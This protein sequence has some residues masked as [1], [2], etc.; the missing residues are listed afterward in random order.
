MTR[1]AASRNTAPG[2]PLT[3]CRS[4]CSPVS[5]NLEPSP[6]N[7][8]ATLSRP[9][10]TRIHCGAFPPPSPYTSTSAARSSRSSSTSPTVT[11][12][13]KRAARSSRSRRSTSKRGRPSCTRRRA[14]E[15][16]C[17]QVV[18]DLPTTSAIS[19]N[20]NANTSCST[21]TARCSGLSRSSSSRAAIDNESASSAACS[22]SRYAVDSSSVRS[23]S[24]SHWPTYDSRRT[25]ADRSTSMETRVTIADR[26]DLSEIGVVVL[27]W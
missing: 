19:L 25:R 9:V 5:A 26:N 22:G 23:G 3:S 20:G 12:S 6:A 17:R 16:S 4:T 1:P 14:R 10:T 7:I 2:W 21:K 15:A 24:G 27:A 11:A 18:S 13:K 8:R